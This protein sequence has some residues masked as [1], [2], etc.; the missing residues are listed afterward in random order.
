MKIDDAV[1]VKAHYDAD[2]QKEWD[3]LAGGKFEFRLASHYMEK[4]IKPSDSVLDIGGGPGRYSIWL[5]QKGCDVTLLDLSEQSIEF[6]RNKAADYGVSIKTFTGDARYISANPKLAKKYDHVLIMGPLYHLVDESDRTGVV[7]GVISH[8]KKG[9]KL[10]ASFIS[11]IGG[12]VFMLREF[13]ELI[14]LPAEQH[15]VDAL[16]GGRSYGGDGFTRAFFAYPDSIVPFMEQFPLKKLHLFAQEGISSPF[17]HRI[18]PLKQ[19]AI[20]EWFRISLAVCE[21][22]EFLAYAEHLMYV[23]EK[24][25]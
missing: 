16:V 23:G 20:D 19:E 5:A 21:K 18:M 24:T 12:M 25:K 10:F 6:A 22:E 11:I 13:P 4:H 15:F 17:V 14:T 7:R 9:G 1:I 2:P 8:L 3:R